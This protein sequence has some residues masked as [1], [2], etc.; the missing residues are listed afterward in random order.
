MCHHTRE[1][2][3]LSRVSCRPPHLNVDRFHQ[4]CLL[5][6][7]TSRIGE[8]C[9]PRTTWRPL[10]LFEQP[11]SSSFASHW[12][13]FATPTRRYH[14]RMLIHPSHPCVWILL[15]QS[16]IV[17]FR[18]GTLTSPPPPVPDLPWGPHPHGHQVS[19]LSS[20]KGN[21]LLCELSFP[22]D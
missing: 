22:P 5:P 8:D 21:G 14:G 10:T 1:P 17:K 12:R 11:G 18:F 7:R 6:G 13:F 3:V 16:V 20:S 2:T 9:R 19:D 15:F 4:P